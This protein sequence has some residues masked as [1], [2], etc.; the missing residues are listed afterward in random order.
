MAGVIAA[1]AVQKRLCADRGEIAVLDVRERGEHARGHPLFAAS[2]PLGRLELHIDRLVPRRGAP[3]AVFDDG[4]PDDRAARAAARLAALG[5]TGARVLENGLAGW[6]AA[7]LEV[8]DGVHAPSKAF[9]EIVE[10]ACGT[11]R[12]TARE[13]AAMRDSGRRV[14]ILDSRPF[15]EYRRMR[16]PGGVCAPGVELARRVRDL[17][18]EPE[19]P[20][21]VNCAG[22]TRSIIGAQSLIDAGAPNPVAALENGTMGWTLAGFALESGAGRMAPPPSAAAAAWARDARDRLAARFRV[23]RLDG[24]ALA[25]RR[26]EAAE[27]TLYLCDV[28]TAEEYEAGHLPGARHTPGGQLVQAT[29]AYAPVRGA[30]LVAIDDDGARATVAAMWLMRMGHRDVAAFALRD[31][32]GALETGPEPNRPPG[33]TPARRAFEIDAMRLAGMKPGRDMTLVD[34]AD[35]RRY[36]AGHIPGAVWGLRARAARLARRLPEAA[37]IVLTSPD[38][39]VAHLAAPELARHVRAPVRVLRGGTDAWA[40]AG[41]PLA[42]GREGML[43]EPVDV[44][45]APYD[46]PPGE[47]EAAMRAYL[48]WET[49]LPARIARDAAARFH[50]GGPPPV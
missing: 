13:L 4:P 26:A 14:A 22:R 40:A 21:V 42:P 47:A 44:H 32:D 45:P 6:R 20:V 17:A 38:S 25:R 15:D 7:G 9:G 35:S 19:T 23:R 31:H 8:F 33:L 36:R 43:D 3:V 50:P 37:A 29:D 16:V 28:R 10:A 27:R 34:F 11:P 30:R 46:L 1:A 12:V 2:L 5:W 18:P 24:E 49:G 41:L 48:D 39:L